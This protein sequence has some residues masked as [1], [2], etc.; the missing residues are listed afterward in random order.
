MI[1]GLTQEMQP[2]RLKNTS[3]EAHLGEPHRH[4]C[5]TLHGR[6]QRERPFALK[7]DGAVDFSEALSG[8]VEGSPWA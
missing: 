1:L 5:G 6:E 8:V 3:L 4:S 2:E 7:R